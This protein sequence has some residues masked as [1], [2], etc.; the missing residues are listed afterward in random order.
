M[1]MHNRFLVALAS[2]LALLAFSGGVALA[3]QD[4]E[5]PQQVCTIILNII[6]NDQYANQRGAA[7]FQYNSQFIQYI[8][9]RLEISPEIVQTCIQNIENRQDDDRDND[10]DNDD[11]N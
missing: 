11:N 10:N 1:G 7:L 8:S 2:A 4:R 3:Q 6:D 9:Q 5:D